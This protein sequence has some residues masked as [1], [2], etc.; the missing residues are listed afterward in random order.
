MTDLLEQLNAPAQRRTASERANGLLLLLA[1][2][3]LAGARTP[4]PP[5]PAA[6]GCRWGIELSL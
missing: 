6:R 5:A 3:L 1:L 4:R 2:V